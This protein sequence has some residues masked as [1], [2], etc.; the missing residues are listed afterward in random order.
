[1]NSFSWNGPGLLTPDW[2][3][4]IRAITRPK[5]TGFGSHSGLLVELCTG[6]WVVYD[7]APRNGIRSS[8]TD[9]FLR[10]RRYT[11]GPAVT[12]HRAVVAAM[13]RLRV[14]LMSPLAHVYDALG[15]NC[16]HLV[17]YVL[18][19]QKRSPQVAGAVLTAAVVAV[20]SLL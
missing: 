12:D 8:R 14:L 18:T 7:H 6:Q 19:G 20:A 3:R 9:E 11:I 5:L 4:S 1:M 13:S 16:E 10:G 17:T 15:N 2:V